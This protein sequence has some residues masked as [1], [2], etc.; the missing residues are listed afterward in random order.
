MTLG[1]GLVQHDTQTYENESVSMLP[2]PESKI[3]S[4]Q[5]KNRRRKKQNKNKTKNIGSHMLRRI[6]FIIT[7]ES[8]IMY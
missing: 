7:N 8:N 4:T 2:C 6:W 3:T 5:H 1:R